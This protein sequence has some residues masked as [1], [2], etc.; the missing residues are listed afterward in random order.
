VK[1]RKGA[2]SHNGVAQ[3]KA[4][5]TKR[6]SEERFAGMG[7]LGKE[8]GERSSIGSSITRKRRSTAAYRPASGEKRESA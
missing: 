2:R 5:E 6:E 7:S 4:V 8:E 3:R 1:L